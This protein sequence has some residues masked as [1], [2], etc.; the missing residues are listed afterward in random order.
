MVIKDPEV[1]S[2]GIFLGLL[3]TT[4]SSGGM[5][6]NCPHFRVYISNRLCPHLYHILQFLGKGDITSLK[7]QACDHLM[8]S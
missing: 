8:Q 5:G 2:K 3:T 1:R 4:V 6:S 7:R